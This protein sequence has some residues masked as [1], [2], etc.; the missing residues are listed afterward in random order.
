MVS[1][2]DLDIPRG[3]IETPRRLLDEPSQDIDSNRIVSGFDDRDLSSGGS[4]GLLVLS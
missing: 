2:E 4:H 3:G 1:L